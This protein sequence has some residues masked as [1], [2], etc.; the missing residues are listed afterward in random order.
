MPFDLRLP[1]VVRSGPSAVADGFRHCQF[2]IADCQLARSLDTNRKSAIA[3][4]Q[5][6]APIRYRGR[7]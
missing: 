1:S 3:N 5:I 7:Y 2:S 4:R 6:A